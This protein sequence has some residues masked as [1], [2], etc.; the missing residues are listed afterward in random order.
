MAPHS[1][2]AADARGRDATTSQDIH[3]GPRQLL[4]A[5]ADSE[6]KSDDGRP[7]LESP[8]FTVCTL[9]VGG[10]N[11]NSFEFEMRGDLTELG[12][13]WGERYQQANSCLSESGPSTVQGLEKAVDAA[14]AQMASEPRSTESVVTSLLNDDTWEKALERVT[15]DCPM[16]FNACNLASLR[17]GRPAPLEMPENLLKFEANVE[18]TCQAQFFGA[19]LRWL[20]S[21]NNE[22]WAAWSKRSKKYSVSLGDAVAGLLIFDAMCFEALRRMYPSSGS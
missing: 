16:L 20:H 9:N 7:E 13:A 21:T 4:D 6:I 8:V 2:H 3:A 1:P 10:R 14:Y 22:D 18:D 12:E 5:M 11:T 19:W 15:R 17:V